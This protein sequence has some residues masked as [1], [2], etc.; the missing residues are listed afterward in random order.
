MA[1][2]ARLNQHSAIARRWRGEA[3]VGGVIHGAHFQWQPGGEF[4][5]GLL[6]A[7]QEAVLV[8]HDAVSIEAV[9]EP[10]TERPPADALT[11]GAAS[12]EAEGVGESGEA[13]APAPRSLADA[14]EPA[15]NEPSAV[16]AQPAVIARPRPPLRR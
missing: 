11:R 8:G 13:L 4:V 3:R 6:T 9:D 10:A 12:G 15:T 1:S 16:P 14:L 2:R 5:T 7:D